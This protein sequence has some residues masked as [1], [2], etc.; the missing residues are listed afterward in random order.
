MEESRR[1]QKPPRLAYLR[2]SMMMTLMLSAPLRMQQAQQQR[3]QRAAGSAAAG[4]S[5]T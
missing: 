3:G 2:K 4:S 5:Y 1:F